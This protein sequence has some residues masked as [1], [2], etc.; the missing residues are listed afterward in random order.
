M[1]SD[2]HLDAT[3]DVKTATGE[4]HIRVYRDAHHNADHIALVKGTI[5]SD[6]A[7]LVRVHSECLTGDVLGSQHC[8]CGPQKERSMAAIADAGSGIFLYMKQEGRGIGIVNK[9]KAY[10]IQQE[11]G[12][13][14]Y[15][16]NKALGL[17]EDLR[18]Y[19]IASQILA[20]CG[21]KKIRL[22][23]NNPDKVA[24]LRAHG[25]EIV[26]QVLV[27]IAP[28]G[29]NDGYLKAKREHGHMLGGV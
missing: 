21:A 29:V 9:I 12:L 13:D 14:T 11:Q 23:T 8:D 15:E 20:D 16:A 3:A 26:D 17:P 5:D 1:P 2:I 22:L 10:A 6:S 4:W 7:T 24:G 18:D 27:E 28:N 19:G 25:L